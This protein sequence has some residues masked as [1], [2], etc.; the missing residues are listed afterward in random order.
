LFK[1]EEILA[2]Q[3]ASIHNIT[4][5]HWVFRTAREAILAGNFHE[6][7]GRQLARFG[8]EVADVH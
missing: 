6:W 8:A 1:A 3:L 5:Y 2:L 4:F 7:K